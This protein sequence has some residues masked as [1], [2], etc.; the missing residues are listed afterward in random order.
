MK[1]KF[2]FKFSKN[3]LQHKTV[4]INNIQQQNPSLSAVVDPTYSMPQSIDYKTE[5]N[6]SCR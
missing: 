4:K 6:F 3:K 5:N 1:V 2:N